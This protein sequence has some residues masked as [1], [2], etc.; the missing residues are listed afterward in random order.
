MRM[1]K[2]RPPMT[3]PAIADASTFLLAGEEGLDTE[4]E[5]GLGFPVEE[6]LVVEPFASVPPV[7]SVAAA[8]VE[9]VLVLVLAT[10]PFDTVTAAPFGKVVVYVVLVVVMTCPFVVK[11]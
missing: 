5:L 2:A 11:V 8:P 7:P 9:L 10:V 4:L 3:P 1:R 6:P